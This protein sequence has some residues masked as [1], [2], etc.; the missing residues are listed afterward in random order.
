MIW[1]WILVGVAALFLITLLFALFCMHT[2]FGTRCEGNPN[3]KY[4]THEDFD[5]LEAEPVSFKSDK[6]QSINGFVYTCYDKEPKAIVVFAHG[7]GGGHLSYTTEIHTLAKAGYA[8]LAYDN[9]GTM[10]SEGKAL[11]SF[12]QAVKDLRSALKFISE[13]EELKGF[14]IVLAG[15]SWGAYTVCQSLAF[16]EERVSGV[17]AF[18]P[19]DSTAKV[20]CDSMKRMMK[21]PMGWL[22]PSMWLASVIKGGISASHTCTSILLKTKKVPVMLLQGD[23]DEMVTLKNSPISYL[24][25][26]AKD[27][28]T[29]VLY[30]GRAHNVYQ[31]KA[32]EDYLNKTF[33]EISKIKKQY[34]KKGLPEE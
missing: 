23:K 33:S 13:T 16:A 19:P 27:N 10:A 1:L 17:V 12:Y 18:S 14:K 15:H 11:G 34:G 8:V 20:V 31:S 3:L 9:T 24:D 26:M 6:G 28:I 7:M 25:I 21:I 30:E 32:S 2:A 29:S 4:F 22:L 5:D